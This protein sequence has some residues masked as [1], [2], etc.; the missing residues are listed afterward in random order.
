MFF[1]VFW[2]KNIIKRYRQIDWSCYDL[3]LHCYLAFKS[4]NRFCFLFNDWDTKNGIFVANQSTMLEQQLTHQ[5]IVKSLYR[6][7]WVP[8]ITIA[9]SF[10]TGHLSCPKYGEKKMKLCWLMCALLGY[11]CNTYLRIDVRQMNENGLTVK[12]NIDF[13]HILYDIRFYL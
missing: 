9:C 5:S 8:V 2:Q 13:F 1:V 11:C 10:A 4:I 3:W 12:L 7:L 6:T